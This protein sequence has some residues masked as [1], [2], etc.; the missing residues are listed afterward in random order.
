MKAKTL[1]FTEEEIHFQIDEIS[2]SGTL[3]IPHKRE[4]SPVVI[5]LSGYG[6]CKRDF[7]GQGLKK[8]RIIS[9]HLAENGIASLRYDDRGAGNSSPVIWSDYTFNDLAKEVLAIIKV[10]QKHRKTYSTQIGLLG[11]SLGA[12]IAPLVAS[13]SKEVKFLVLLG[14]HGLIGTKTAA[15]TRKYLGRILGET[16]KESEEG[17]K[18]VEKLFK[19][20]L[21]EGEWEEVCLLVQEK[22]TG[23]FLN[24]PDESKQMFK[25]L[26]NYLNSTYEGFLITDGNTPMYRSFLKYDPSI[27]LS[28]TTC[29]S[30]LL[31][32]E[33]DIIHP[34]DQHMDV[35]LKALKH[36]DNNDV[37]VKVFP[38]T[39]HEFTTSNSLKRKEFTPNFLQVIINW[40]QSILE[41]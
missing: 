7:E 3:T 37:T 9:S 6:P 13:H 16:D 5:L 32:G 30:L 34:P 41:V 36:G 39:N 40:I 2:L 31:F 25:T 11:H 1:L 27:S 17:V 33:L 8:F 19:V 14:G 18:L 29:P 38:Q 20:I 21:A 22:I 24:L 4:K 35:M 26:D 12:A 28:K 10:L 15:T 23:K